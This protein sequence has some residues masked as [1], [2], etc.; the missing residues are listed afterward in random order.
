MTS[1]IVLPTPP[2]PVGSYKAGIIRGGIGF[3][4]GQF[5]LVDGKLAFTGHVGAELTTDEGFEAAR[6][7]GLNV[8]AQ[9]ARLTDQFNTLD[10]LLRLD[11]YVAS[12]KGFLDQPAVLNGASDLFAE[13]LGEQGDHARTAFSVSQLPLNSPIELAVTF[14]VKS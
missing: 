9:I 11:G 6:L 7:A 4:S 8:L 5:P 3:V 2:N 10:G 14:A 12:A 1:K 13:Y